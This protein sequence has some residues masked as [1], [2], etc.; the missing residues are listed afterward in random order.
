MKIVTHNKHKY[1]E[2]KERFLN[3]NINLEWVNFEYKEIQADTLE[4]IV[5][6][7]LEFVKD[8]VDPPFFLEDAGLFI[9]ALNGFPGP[10]SSYVHDKIGNNGILKLLLNENNRNAEFVAVIG[11]FDGKNYHLFR[12]SVKGLITYEE[13]GKNGFGY[14]PIFRPLN[15]EKTFAEMEINEKNEFSH[16][17]K[18]FELFLNHLKKIQ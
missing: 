16:R 7:S 2:Y 10:Y 12:G 6:F 4:D 17:A 9:E 1:L 18:A 8:K 13:R 5:K 3:F 14:D 11:Y 15:S